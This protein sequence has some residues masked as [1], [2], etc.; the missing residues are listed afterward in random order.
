ML[1]GMVWRIF[2]LGRGR[3]RGKAAGA[4]EGEAGE[5][6]DEA[7]PWVSALAAFNTVQATLAVARLR[8]AGIPVIAR[9]EAASSVYAVGV[10]I[11]GRI[12]IMVPEPLADKARLVLADTLDAG[13]D[14]EGLAEFDD[15]G[16]EDGESGSTAGD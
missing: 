14:E 16:D 1:H 12:D 7:V 9:Q 5:G 3:D 13:L 2:G 10:G 8:D 11:L 4:A 6:D 15:A